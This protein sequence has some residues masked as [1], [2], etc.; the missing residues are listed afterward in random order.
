VNGQDRDLVWESAWQLAGL[1]A[2]STGEAPIE[3]RG[4][5]E[6][7]EAISG[8]PPVAQISAHPAG[9][10]EVTGAELKLLAAVAEPVHVRSGVLRTGNCP[11]AQITAIVV[12]RW[13]PDGAR[14][15]LGVTRAGSLRRGGSSVPLGRALRGLGVTRR[16]LSV[17]LTTCRRDM[18]GEPQ[19]LY[20][21]AL[22]RAPTGRPLAIVKECV[23]RRFLQQHPAP[24]PCLQTS[25]S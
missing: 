14:A 21:T 8:Q 3:T 22:L 25:V 18:S 2:G 12:T 24:W 15:R 5:T 17:E 11:A 20:S 9:L 10:G 16:Q 23:Y 7:C 1:L 4:L 19:V 13:V 6:L